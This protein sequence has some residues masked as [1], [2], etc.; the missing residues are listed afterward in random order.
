MIL[1]ELGRVLGLLPTLLLI[2]LTGAGGAILAR[3]EGLR[4]FFQF[5]ESIAQAQIPGQAVLDGLSVLIG[6]AF[7]VTPGVLTDVLGFLC[8]YHSPDIGF[9]VGYALD[10]NRKLRMAPFM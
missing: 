4:V 10:L 5:R 3:L 6:G 2:L 7:L 8:C 9:N 1:I